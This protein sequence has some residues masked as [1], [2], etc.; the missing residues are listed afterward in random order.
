MTSIPKIWITICNISYLLEWSQFLDILIKRDIYVVVFNPHLYSS[1]IIYLSSHLSYRQ[2][3]LYIWTNLFWIFA[4][5][6]MLILI[7]VNLL[8]VKSC[9]VQQWLT[10]TIWVELNFEFCNLIKYSIT[11]GVI[12]AALYSNVDNSTNQRQTLHDFIEL[13]TCWGC[14]TPLFGPN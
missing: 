10:N 2:N 3:Y 14:L 7:F 11:A 8:M 1:V 6:I 5:E 12:L 13:F 4:S 9:H